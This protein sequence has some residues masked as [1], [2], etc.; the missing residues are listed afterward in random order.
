M[1][2]FTDYAFRAQVDDAL[3]TVRKILDTTK[4]PVRPADVPHTYDDKFDLVEQASKAAIVATANALEVFGV[5]GAALEGMRN[6]VKANKVRIVVVV[7]V[8]VFFFS[9]LKLNEKSLNSRFQ[10][11]YNLK[12]DVHSSRKS[13]VK[14]NQRPNTSANGVADSSAP[15]RP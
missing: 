12:N 3:E 15:T 14:K 4:H 7:V 8:V 13:F 6:W 5:S 9:F 1:N 10:F 11:F 2:T